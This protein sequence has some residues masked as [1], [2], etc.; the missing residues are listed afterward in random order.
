MNLLIVADLFVTKSIEYLLVIGFLAALI[1]FWRL[2]VRRPVPQLAPALP[3]PLARSS[4]GW[5]ALA[6][7]RLYHPGHAWA[8]PER[9]GLVTLGV[10]DT[11]GCSSASP[12]ERMI[13]SFAWSA[14]RV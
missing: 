6:L 7:E 8:Q 12:C 2:L 13:C 10:D 11:T 5:F 3:S 9:D 14:S 1:L 4:A